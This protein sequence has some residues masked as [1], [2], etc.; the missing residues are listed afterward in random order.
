MIFS[1]I[2]TTITATLLAASAGLAAAQTGM[3]AGSVA[4]D[5][6]V[7]AELAT[8]ELNAVN[9][10][11]A[12]VLALYQAGAEIADSCSSACLADNIRADLCTALAHAKPYVTQKIMLRAPESC[13]SDKKEIGV[14]AGSVALECSSSA[15]GATL[16]LNSVKDYVPA[17]LVLYLY[18]HGAKVADSCPKACLADDLRDDLCAALAHAKP[19]IA[20]KILVPTP[21]SCMKPAAAARA[22]SKPC[23]KNGEICNTDSCA[24]CCSGHGVMDN[25]NPDLGPHMVCVGTC[26]GQGEACGKTQKDCRGQ[27]CSGHAVPDT[28]DPNGPPFGWMCVDDA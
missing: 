4:L 23:K 7:S 26:L 9:G 3:C 27:C 16:A 18:R 13:K 19:Y 11:S 14:C 10:P 22:T 17:G 12:G 1:R 20:A 6:R 8:K 15:E 25:R 24:S 21:E 5:C 28:R 2:T